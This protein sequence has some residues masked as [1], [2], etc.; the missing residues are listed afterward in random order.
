M[1]T[2]SFD[3]GTIVLYGLNWAVQ[4]KPSGFIWDERVVGWRLEAFRYRETVLWLRKQNIPFIDQA[5]QYDPK[6]F[7]LQS[8]TSLPLFDYFATGLMTGR[9]ARLS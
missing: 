3:Q 7:S 4:I 5:R 2:L 1:T 9:S 6:G 8:I